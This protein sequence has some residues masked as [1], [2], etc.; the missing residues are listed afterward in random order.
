VPFIPTYSSL[1]QP[2][3][4]PNES[5]RE[6]QAPASRGHGNV[7]ERSPL[8]S[9]VSEQSTA[10]RLPTSSVPP[11]PSPIGQSTFSQTVSRPCLPVLSNV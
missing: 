5:R 1:Q 6:A 2:V 8:L 9:R 10:P 7:D 4:A 3:H 11:K